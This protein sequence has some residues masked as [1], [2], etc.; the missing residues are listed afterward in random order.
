M[1]LCGLK[2][3]DE[4]GK[5]REWE[6]IDTAKSELLQ[7]E[8]D[9]LDN[10]VRSHGNFDIRRRVII[11]FVSKVDAVSVLTNL[12]THLHYALLAIKAGKHVLVEKPAGNNVEEIQRMKM[13]AENAG[14][15]CV[16]VHNYI[17]EA[18]VNRTRELLNQG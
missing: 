18:G 11:G 10:T 3:Q 8:I 6:K 16:P 4:S 14:V 2:Y 1:S 9:H 5:T 17:Y 15:L 7:H 13:A 12:E